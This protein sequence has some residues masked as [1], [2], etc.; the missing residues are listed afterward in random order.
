MD[1]YSV[2]IPFEISVCEAFARGECKFGEFCILIHPAELSP[3]CEREVEYEFSREA[4]DACTRCVSLGFPC[5]KPGRPKGKEHPCSECR[6]FGGEKICTLS[7]GS[8]NDVMWKEMIHRKD[9]AL[10]SYKARDE[11]RTRKGKLVT[12]SPMPADKIARNW[13]G[14]SRE[15]LLAKGDPLPAEVRARPRA[16]LTPPGKN[17]RQERRAAFAAATGMKKKAWGTNKAPA[18]ETS[19]PYS[20]PKYELPDIPIPQRDSRGA[21]AT[22]VTFYLSG[23]SVVSASVSYP[24]I[25]GERGAEVI[26]YPAARRQAELPIQRD[27]TQT[28][29]GHTDD[30]LVDSAE[31][32]DANSVGYQ[33]SDDE[34]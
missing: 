13:Q 27:P 25:N 31:D 33:S 26:S 8:R 20:M 10:P 23:E 30:K 21:H 22:S 12:P 16:Y 9:C 2:E 28:A 17:R 3:G 6:W 18:A 32:D 14:E 4:G 7:G 29:P 1:A 34:S 24:G 5:D 15:Q 19:T 11:A